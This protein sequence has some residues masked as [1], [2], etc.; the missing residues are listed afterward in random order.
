M[1]F[2]EFIRLKYLY[3]KSPKM[4]E[5]LVKLAPPPDFSLCR[6]VLLQDG[7]WSTV[8][9][10]AKIGVRA[11]LANPYFF[12][13]DEMGGMK[14]AQTAIAAQFLFLANKI[15]RVLIICPASVRP[16]WFDRDIG[17]IALHAFDSIPYKLVHEYHVRNSAWG[18]APKGSRFLHWVITNYEFI[19]RSER[20]AELKTLCNPRTMIV[21]DESSALKN[22]KSETYRVSK[23]L[24][25]LC[26]QVVE[27]NGTPGKPMDMYTQA[28]ILSP[29]IMG[30]RSFYHYRAR[31]AIMG[32]WQMKQ[33][34]QYQNLE[35]M[36]RRMAPYILRR[37]KDA[38]RDYPK[39]LPPVQ[40]VV[41]LSD[42]TW[43]I[44]KEMREEMVAFLSQN[45]IAVAAQAAVRSLRLSQLT[46]GFVGG[47]EEESTEAEL[48]ASDGIMPPRYTTKE[49]SREKLDFVLDL[50]EEWLENDPN[51][52]LLVWCRF[53]P[54]LRRFFTDHAA[55]YPGIVR[56]SCAGPSMFGR[57]KKLER[58]DAL[59]LLNP[60][61]APPGPVTVGGT[62]GTG[63]LGLNFTACHTVINMSCD[64]S[65][66][67]AAQSAARVDRP[68]QLYPVSTFDI[69]AEGPR[70]QKTIDHIIA[71]ARRTNE[72]L[73]SW[74]C[75]AWIKALTEE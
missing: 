54:E 34:T 33:I 44:Y 24:R 21:F 70:G 46:S 67:K 22:H 47:V 5:S 39:A 29:T 48:E 13:G 27:L 25:M 66:Y 71:K 7:T 11:I 50:Q 23:I 18:N 63:A 43:R 57:G 61:T 45:T 35:D 2:W 38:F 49:V 9:E 60:K 73:A 12:I 55:R 37:E 56:G 40:R 10:H 14:S 17:E 36:Q 32:G 1:R 58:A 52:K 74:T 28:D 42:E 26:S 3:P 16:V 8:K 75:S 72:E 41:T 15:D 62:Y 65:Y 6:P 64:Y 59:R 20:L 19:R 53:I 51:L 4:P 69:V 68:G 30:C 31:Y